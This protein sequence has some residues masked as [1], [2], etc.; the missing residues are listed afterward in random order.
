[1]EKLAKLEIPAFVGLF[2]AITYIFLKSA[3]ESPMLHLGSPQY[4]AAF[5]AVVTGVVFFAIRFLIPRNLKL[6]K[7]VLALFLTSMPL[8]YLW[9]AFVAHDSSGIVLELIG[10]VIYSSLA[11]YGY[12]RSV[13]ILSLG[14]AA[15]G[16]VWDL[17]HHNHSLYIENWYSLGCFVVDIAYGFLVLTQLKAHATN[18]NSNIPFRKE[19]S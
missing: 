14:I 10:V 16:I 5:G 19:L 17:L 6:E 7:L 12:Q 13:L 1:M 11:I 4:F 3:P 9:S 2:L 8:I 15:H 18:Q